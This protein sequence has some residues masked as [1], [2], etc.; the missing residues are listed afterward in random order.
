M[1]QALIRPMIKARAGVI[2]NISSVVG[3]TGNAGQANYA[4]SKAAV[5]GFTRSLAQEVASRNVRA[6]CIVPGFIETPMTEA[7]TDLQ[8]AAIL[9][10]I[11][12]GRMGEAAD[13]ANMA[14]FLAS[15]LATYITGQ[16]FT[17]DG[18]MT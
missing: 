15:P 4:A 1:C 8:K 18:G 9:A 17:V 14:L 7:L 11:P 16:L 6:N 3:V 13:I 10:K 12:L 5:I 2:L